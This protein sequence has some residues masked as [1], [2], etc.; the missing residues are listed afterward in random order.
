LLIASKLK[1]WTMPFLT[2]FLV[3]FAIYFVSLDFHFLVLSDDSAYIFRNPYL[4]KISLANI[5]AIFS[6]I[7]FSDYLPINLLSY[8]WDFT[9]W[10]FNSFGYRLT[11]VVLHS[12]NAC[13]LFAILRL[14]EVPK[15]ACWFSALI[16]IA[17]PVQVESVVWISERK[18]L[19]SSL[20]IFLSLWFY[21][22]HAMSSRF[23]RSHYYF[24]LL[25]FVLALLSKSISV[26]LPCIF[27]LLDFLVLKRKWMVM[28][29]IPFFLLS[30]LAG[31]ATIYSQEAVGAIRE[32]PGGSFSTAFLYTLRVYWDYVVC[33]I[34][35]FQL[36]PRY[37]FS[38][39]FLIDPQSLLAYLFFIAV[40]FYVARNFRSHPGLVFAIGWFVVWLIPV[41][42][43]IPISVLRQ[44][45]YLY[46][47][48]IA[49]IVLVCIWLESWG[50]GQ[51]KNVL[52]NSIIAVVVFFLGSLSFLHAFV[53]A[54]EHAFWQRVANQ[55]P[56]KVYAQVEAGYHCGL[57]ED[58]VCE[59]KRYRQA[60]AIEPDH[61]NALN[62]LGLLMMKRERY[63]EAQVLL[64]KSIRIDPTDAVVY[65]NRIA[66]AKKSGI[67]REN[68]PEWKRKADLFK[69]PKKRKDLSLGGFRFR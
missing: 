20:F 55:Y 13:L 44:D 39:I 16:F 17:H 67:G 61:A 58:E 21:L 69:R 23:C 28:E 65:S 22:R 4:Q 36:S 56:Q 5:V 27:V 47:P 64:D 3:G 29:K 31:L 63:G 8:S 66:L 26:M 43:L 54:S 46:L 45:R 34:F 32:Y 50:Q 1:D 48:S 19:L 9:W 42:N 15:R 10:G 60:L 24:C 35:P 41:S 14:L 40:C 37:F 52:V 59:E 57:I 2:F 49:V 38:N 25:S 11:Q 6:N 12:L 62:N 51:R 68:I 33:L 53:Y 7:H 30:L 18:N